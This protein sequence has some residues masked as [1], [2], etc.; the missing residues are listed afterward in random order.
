MP[1]IE[2]TIYNI[3]CAD[4]VDFKA[5]LAV[6]GP[7]DVIQLSACTYNMGT[8]YDLE[9]DIN[10]SKFGVD[11]GFLIRG[12][13]A[14]PVDTVVK[15]AM[16]YADV[17]VIFE[18][19]T[20]TAEDF[21]DGYMSVIEEDSDKAFL[22]RN[23]IIKSNPNRTTGV[24]IMSM[25]GGFIKSTIQGMHAATLEQTVGVEMEGDVVM[26]DSVVQGFQ[27]GIFKQNYGEPENYRIFDD[28]DF[29][30]NN[31]E[32]CSNIENIYDPVTGICTVTCTEFCP[33]LNSN[34]PNT[35]TGNNVQIWGLI[36]LMSED[37]TVLPLKV[38]FPKVTKT[39]ETAA[40]K[41]PAAF[42]VKPDPTY[43]IGTTPQYY[44]FYSTAELKRNKRAKVFFRKTFIDNNFVDTSKIVARFHI[45]N[46]WRLA[47]LPLSVKV[48]SNGRAFYVVKLP[49]KKF[50][51][52]VTISFFETL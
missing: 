27:T 10:E 5:K 28:N 34:S 15:A 37:N 1:L 2:A 41:V 51:K 48:Q 44:Q 43:L 22:V 32:C 29:T 50:L 13:S 11:E 17:N 38:K 23:C 46:S 21:T 12:G 36:N 52:G 9:T 30:G 40:Y 3:G 31:V 8:D 7:G 4:V 20:L 42:P 16:N 45:G 35:P 26:L 14:D 47:P 33:L 18:D 6:A 19:L 25:R 49:K 39:G 24:D